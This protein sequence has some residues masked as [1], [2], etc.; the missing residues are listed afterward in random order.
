MANQQASYRESLKSAGLIGGSKVLEIMIGL[1]RTKAQALILG[2]AG[3][4]IYG[5]YQTATNVVL[6]GANLGIDQSGVRQVAEA[7][8]KGDEEK[9]IVTVS[10][11]QQIVFA[12]GALGAIATFFLSNTFSRSLFN[13]EDHAWAF[14][15]LSVMIFIRLFSRGY[16][17]IIQGF[18]RIGDLAASRIIGA[19]SSVI[20]GVPIIYFFGEKGIP[21]SM[22]FGALVVAIVHFW[23]ARRVKVTTRWVPFRTLYEESKTLISFG[24]VMAW[25]GFVA[26]AVFLFERTFVSRVLG[27]DALGLYQAS[28]AL[29]SLYVGMVLQAMAADYYPRLTAVSDDNEKVN[30]LVNEQAEVAILIAAPGVIAT[31]LLSPLILYIIYSSEFIGASRILQWQ[32]LGVFGQVIS[33]PL[34]II[35]LAKGRKSWAMGLVL[36]ANFVRA[37]L[38]IIFVAYF[39]LIGIGIALSSLYLF[40]IV[41]TNFAARKLSDFRWSSENKRHW[42]YLLPA[43]GSVFLITVIFQTWW[44]IVICTLIFA[45]CSYYSFSNLYAAVGSPDKSAVLRKLQK[46]PL[47]GKYL[48]KK[49]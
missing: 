41:A 12:T 22:M 48:K 30:T 35:A 36:W 4:G 6:R 27:L 26:S 43:V 33:W 15:V 5:L 39:G 19:I 14:Q 44:S 20:V 29:S 2:P 9:I 3:I 28:S 38:I 11:V 47:I 24:L 45:A 49:N 21:Y 40:H 42:L 16:S 18:R 23:F 37:S 46:L 13:S 8:G 17:V 34:G 25:N 10:T 31:I 1:I 7:R 32:I